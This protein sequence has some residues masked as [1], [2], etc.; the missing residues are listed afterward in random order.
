[1]RCV[2]ITKGPYAA[3]KH[4]LPQLPQWPSSMPSGLLINT[5]L[6]VST[7]RTNK[8]Y[9]RFSECSWSL[10]TAAHNQLKKRHQGQTI[11]WV[12]EIFLQPVVLSISRFNQICALKKKKVWQ[13]EMLRNTRDNNKSIHLICNM[14]CIKKK[15][16]E[17]LYSNYEL[18]NSHYSSDFQHCHLVC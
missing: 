9:H 14:H 17:L 7:S 6:Q 5:A 15:T 1:M 16:K 11:V 10:M 18:Y 2:V 3:A 12:T 13:Q 4:P 8:K